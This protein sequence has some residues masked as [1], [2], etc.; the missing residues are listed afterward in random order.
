M[1]E[2][3]LGHGGGG[4]GAGCEMY[5]FPKEDSY[6]FM[7]VNL[8]VLVDGPIVDKVNKLKDAIVSVLQH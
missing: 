3:V 5:Y 8:G 2:Q 1:G 7:A 6:V 4:L